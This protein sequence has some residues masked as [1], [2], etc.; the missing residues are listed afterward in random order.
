MPRSPVPTGRRLNWDLI[1]VVAVF[2]VVLGHITHQAAVLHPELTGYPFTIPAQY[3]AAT[4][5]V[6]SA[7]FVC[8]TLRKGHPGRWLWRKAARL[9]PAYLVAVVLTY[10]IMRLAT[11]AFNRQHFGDDWFSILFGAPVDVSPDASPWYVPVGLDLVVNLTMIQNWSVDFHWLD[12]S[13]WTLPVQLMAFCA[14]AVLWPRRWRTDRRVLGL[15]WLLVAGPVVLRFVLFSPGTEPGWVTT[16]LFGLGLHRVHAFAIGVAIWLWARRRVPGWHLGLLLAAT[17]HAQDLHMFPA[18]H[19][20][21]IDP[22]RWPSIIGFAVLLLAICAAARGP[23]WDLPVLRRCAPALS[24]LAGISYGVYL[25]HQELGYILAKALL[26]A[27]VPGWTRL[28]LVLLAAI[29]TGWLLTVA[30]ERPAHRWLTRAAHRRAP[31]PATGLDDLVEPPQ[32]GPA[33][34]SVGGP[35]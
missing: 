33:P 13:Y 30:V 20:T 25:V 7:Y 2:S 18:R 24:W 29:V 3:G 5:L 32:K 35:S 22:S 31:A 4:L 10:V 15:I 26:N 11:A 9:L 19:A 27:G 28:L 6:I 8:A 1:R 17:V 14:A 16:L 34:V 12:G 23:D 21:A